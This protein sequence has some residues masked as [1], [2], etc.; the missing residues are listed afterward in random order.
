MG[1]PLGAAL[2]PSLVVLAAW[3]SGSPGRISV[4][5][6]LRIL[7]TDEENFMAARILLTSYADH[8]YLHNTKTLWIVGHRGVDVYLILHL[9]T[10]L[11]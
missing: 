9:S 1:R 5:V 4:T 3:L 7:S 10:N 8:T 6:R 11:Q 2:R